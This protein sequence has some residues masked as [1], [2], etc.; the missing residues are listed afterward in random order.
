MWM[1]HATGQPATFFL[2]ADSS[3]DNWNGIEHCAALDTHQAG[4]AWDDRNCDTPRY[5]F[6]EY[7]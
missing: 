1:S 6:C 4:G 7:V 3:P 5:F 2:W